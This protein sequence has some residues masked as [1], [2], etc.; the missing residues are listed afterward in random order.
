MRSI[1]GS[2]LALVNHYIVFVVARDLDYVPY[3]LLLLYKL[4]QVVYLL[5]SEASMRIS[6]MNF[7]W[8]LLS[9]LLLDFPEDR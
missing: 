4:F 2:T 6:L 7:S 3:E 1:L 5:D 8:E 9:S